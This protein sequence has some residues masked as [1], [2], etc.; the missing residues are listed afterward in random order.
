MRIQRFLPWAFCLFTVLA[1]GCGR[2]ELEQPE[3]V[4][5]APMDA[6][7]VGDVPTDRPRDVVPVD[8]GCTSNAQCD[9]GV[10]CNG[11]EQCNAGRCERLAPVD[12]ADAIDCTQDRCDEAARMCV[13]Q[14]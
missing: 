11:V 8:Q 5:T 6:L 12:C 4:P 7:D 10:F 3:D 9:D 13:H 1:V 2:S 14:P